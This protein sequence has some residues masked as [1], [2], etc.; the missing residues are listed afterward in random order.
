MDSKR[1][2]ARIIAAALYALIFGALGSYFASRSAA[3]NEVLTS[4]RYAQVVS[5][6]REQQLDA[7]KIRDALRPDIGFLEAF[8][9][10]TLNLGIVCVPYGL[11]T[12]LVRFVFP[13]NSSPAHVANDV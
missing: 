11:L 2:V 13:K 9:G 1:I 7:R 3:R 5:L 12:A 6:I 8:F 10:A 4:E